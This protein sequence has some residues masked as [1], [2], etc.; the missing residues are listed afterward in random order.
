MKFVCEK[1]G[2]ATHLPDSEPT[3]QS[4]DSAGFGHPDFFRDEPSG[5]PRKIDSSVSSAQPPAPARPSRKNGVV[6]LAAVGFFLAA[7][8]VLG[9]AVLGKDGETKYVER[10]VYRDRVVKEYVRAPGRSKVEGE[11]GKVNEI[12]DLSEESSAGVRARGSRSGGSAKHMADGEEQDEEK[13]KR[14]MAQLGISSSSAGGAPVGSKPAREIEVESTQKRE[15]TETQLKSVVNRNKSGLKLCYERALKQGEAPENKD[16][17]VN[18]KL[19]VGASGTVRN[20]GLSGDGIGIPS[21][22]S[23]LEKSVKRWVFPSSSKGSPVEFPFLFTP[24]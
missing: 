8:V 7:M 4:A 9:V 19:D 3:A 10:I 1:C 20:V 6:M 23:C 15:L 21:L 24:K 2:H 17:R 16:L 13:K 12:G 11:E 14:L 5:R 18:F 22:K